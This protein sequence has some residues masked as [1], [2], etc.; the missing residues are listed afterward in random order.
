MDNKK[1]PRILGKS[2]KTDKGQGMGYNTHIVYFDPSVGRVEGK[3]ISKVC[4][5]ATEG[6]MKAC[7]FGSGNARFK[8][9]QSGRTRKTLRFY[10]D[11]KGFVFQLS[12]EI[13]RAARL[14]RKK[15]MIPT[16]RLN[17]TSDIP[18][19]NV[20]IGGVKLMEVHSDVQFYDYT[21]NPHR[22]R[23]Y[24]EGKMPPNYHLTFSRKEDNWATCLEILTKGGNVAAVFEEVPPTYEG[25]TVI[26]GDKDDLRFLD[27]KGVIVGLK[28][29]KITLKGAKALNEEALKGG[30]VI[31][32][33]KGQFPEWLGDM[34]RE[35]NA[36]VYNA[37]TDTDW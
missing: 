27:P 15:G 4:P 17:G 3:S 21:P 10:E 23:K 13:T 6:C 16:F 12:A 37:P 2:I 14:D 18:W 26:D 9:V 36:I 19:E 29:K 5:H 30:F 7:L 31:T 11:R 34:M 35:F 22:M 25:Y 32:K 24:L 28:Y 1:P 20:R 33:G 8:Q